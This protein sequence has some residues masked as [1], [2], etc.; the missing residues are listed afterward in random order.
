MSH[1]TEWLRRLRIND[2]FQ[3]TFTTMNSHETSAKVNTSTALCNV[4]PIVAIATPVKP[5]H[6]SKRLM[7]STESKRKNLQNVD[8]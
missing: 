3:P 8:N 4:I 7:S 2:S 6:C 5:Q 1:V